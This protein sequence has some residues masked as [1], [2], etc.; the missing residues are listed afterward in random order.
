MAGDETICLQR[1]EGGGQYLLRDVGNGS[2]EGVETNAVALVHHV[3]DQQRPLAANMCQDIA[4][5]AVLE[6][7]VCYLIAHITHDCFFV[8]N[9]KLLFAYLLAFYVC[10]CLCKRFIFNI[11]MQK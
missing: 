7:G 6:N 11:S 3:D 4:D 8:D 5:R 10:I 9:V 1:A 2:V